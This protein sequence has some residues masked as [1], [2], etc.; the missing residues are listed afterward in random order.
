MSHPFPA[1]VARHYNAGPPYVAHWRDLRRIADH[2]VAFTPRV[3]DDYPSIPGPN[4]DP[5]RHYAEMYAYVMARAGK[6]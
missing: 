3:W 5:T 2:W 4:K 6:G 1:Q